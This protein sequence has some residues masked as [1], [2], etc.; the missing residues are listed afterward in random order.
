[1]R[2][3]ILSF[4]LGSLV[5]AVLATS[6][7]AAADGRYPVQKTDAEWRALLTP[8]QY[9]ITRKAHTEPPF[10]GEF[11]NHHEKG[12][13]HCVGCASPLFSSDGK[14]D[15]GTG[16]PS[17][18]APMLEKNLEKR[19]DRSLIEVRTEVLCSRC[20]AHLGHVFRDGP[21]PTGLRYCINSASLRFNKA[22]RPGKAS[23]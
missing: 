23:P 3:A 8:N 16:W 7:G 1:M 19:E 21:R 10:T 9:N 13:Y 14:F 15:S 17:F 4:V 2:P 11:W 5:V 20:G 18:W 22:S 6:V 12:T